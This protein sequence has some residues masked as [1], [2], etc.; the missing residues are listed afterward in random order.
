[1][2]KIAAAILSAITVGMSIGG[3][4]T[5][6]KTAGFNFETKTVTLNSGYE[7]PIY[8]LGTYSLTGD[9]CVASV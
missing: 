9:T 2:K 4:G 1:M 5:A 7:M 8:G 3:G 6:G